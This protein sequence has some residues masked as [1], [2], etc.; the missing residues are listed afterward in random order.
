MKIVSGT[1]RPTKFKDY[2][3]IG[4]AMEERAHGISINAACLDYETS[5]RY[6]E[7]MDCPRL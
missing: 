3:Q 5:A 6:Y 7:H 1:A 4:A 2:E